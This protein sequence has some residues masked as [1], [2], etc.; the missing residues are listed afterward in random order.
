MLTE[1][2]TEAALG[3][4]GI[5]LAYSC[6]VHRTIALHTRVILHRN[7]RSY[8][9]LAYALDMRLHKH[10]RLP[11]VTAAAAA[12]AA[13]A[14]VIVNIRRAYAILQL[15]RSYPIRIG[16]WNRTYKAL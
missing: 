9:Q 12:A 15:T 8:T 14:I 13:R 7:S 5:R 11:P 1:D 10:S 3:G 6:T 4:S 16:I 2:S